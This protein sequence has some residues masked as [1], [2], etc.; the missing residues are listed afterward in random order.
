MLHG[1]FRIPVDADVEARIG[2]RPALEKAQ[3]HVGWGRGITFLQIDIDQYAPLG[4]ET[5][6]DE[7]VPAVV[8]CAAEN[9]H[10]VGVVSLDNGRCGPARAFHEC[11]DRDAELL[12]RMVVCLPHGSST[13]H[14]VEHGRTGHDVII[15]ER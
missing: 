9:T 3:I 5:R 11:R 13:E 14:G 2:R 8:A 10:M 12:A 4:Q 15:P 7:A 1:T 6:H